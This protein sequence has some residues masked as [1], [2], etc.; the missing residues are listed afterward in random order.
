MSSE[1]HFLLWAFIKYEM[2]CKVQGSKT[3]S[4]MEYNE[5]SAISKKASHELTSCEN[6]ALDCVRETR[7]RST[8]KYSTL[9][10]R[11]TARVYA[12][13]VLYHT[14]PFCEVAAS[15]FS[16]SSPDFLQRNLDRPS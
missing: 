14:F 5:Y 8:Q 11:D 1:R 3:A 15:N 16:P 2:L 4:L 10:K 7:F 12:E 13:L 6:E 9:C